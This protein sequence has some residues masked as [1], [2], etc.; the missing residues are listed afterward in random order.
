HTRRHFLGAKVR[1]ASYGYELAPLFLR[2]PRTNIKNLNRVL[3]SR[4]IPGLILSSFQTLSVRLP[5]LD[6]K[7]YAS[8]VLGHTVVEPM[9]DTVAVNSAHGFHLLLNKAFEL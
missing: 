1:A 2:E 9:L 8:I 6:W 7:R 4:G 3:S 5:E